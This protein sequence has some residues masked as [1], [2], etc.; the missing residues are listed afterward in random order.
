MT[1]SGEVGQTLPE[2]RFVSPQL[3]ETGFV[4]PQPPRNRVSMTISGEVRSTR[5]FLR[6]N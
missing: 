5:V 1:I 4:S 3:P 2:T 6:V